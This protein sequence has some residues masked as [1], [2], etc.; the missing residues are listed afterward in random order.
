MK[1]LSYLTAFYFIVFGLTQASAACPNLTLSYTHP[2]QNGCGVPQNIVFNNTSTGTAANNNTWYYWRVNGV[3]VDSSINTIP[4]FTYSFGAPGNYTVRMI[5]RTAGNCRDSI[6]QNIVI[7]SNTP[8]VYNGAALLSYQPI[9]NNCILNP[10]QN[11]N[12][13]IN[14]AS[15]VLLNNYTIIWGD[16]SPNASGVSLAIG[17]AVTHTYTALGLY[18]VRIVT[19]NGTCTDTISGTVF[20]LRPVSTSIKPLPSGQLAGCAPHA[21]TF[22]D[23][24]QNALPGT[25]LTWNF[26]DGNI[27]IR[28]WTQANQPI[29]HTYMPTGVGNCVYTVSLRAFNPNCNTG[30][31]NVSTYTISPVLIFDKDD[32]RI[33]PPTN[34]CLPS[35][36]YTFGNSSVDNCITGQRYYYWDFGD[37]NNSGWITSKGPQTHTFPSYG[38]YT[39][40]LID[41]NGCGS[42]TTYSTVVL[43]TPPQ[44]G[45]TLTP[46]FGCA[47]LTVAVT[48][49]SIGIGNT[50]TWTFT[51]GTPA[52]STLVGRNVTYNN[53][54]TYIVRLAISN[55]C[56]TN[57]IRRDTVRV[58][59]KPIVQIGNAVSGCAP[60]TI[61]PINNTVNQS[62]TATY[63]WD[64]GNGQTS[65]Q[66]NPGSIT[67]NNG[68]NFNIKLVVKDTCG[69]D[70]QLVS[71]T[72][73]T[74]PIAKFSADT[75]CRNTA[76][77]FTGNSTLS[78]GDV[79]TQHKWYFGN[80][81]SSTSISTNQNYTYPTHGIFTAVLKITTDKSCVDVDTFSV[82][83]KPI[84]FVSFNYLPANICDK[85][86][87]N[88][89]A[90]AT[91]NIIQH[92]WSF[93]T[94]DTAKI[95]DTSYLFQA[96]GNYTIIYTATNNTGCLASTTQNI[97]ILPNP[98]ARLFRGNSCSNQVTEFKDSSKV[99]FGNTITQWAWDFDNNGITDS[100]T[101]HATFRFLNAGA[102][103]TKL[104]VTTNNG[105]SNTD[106]LNT[107][108][109]LS[110]LANFNPV[111]TS[112]CVN[113]TFT[114][115]NNS[116]GSIVY[117]WNFGDNANNVIESTA[118]PMK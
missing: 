106:S 13:S 58:Y 94:I 37:G 20:N 53:P 45:F 63:Y 84:P 40:M 92:R 103:N 6:Q 41:S 11:D 48:D 97:T 83:V 93:G 66:R 62:P 46:R 71:I 16:G 27:I 109:Y 108:V 72:V 2:G 44:V 52:S 25:I 79:I 22:Q 36:T 99:G 118:T 116:F 35:L 61:N 102:F 70:S 38:N 55:I 23:S 60:H 15:N 80:G 114:F 73:S 69:I 57:V 24:T 54:G 29:S 26:G 10:L 104:T 7:T 101:Q 47:P 42:D 74:L 31:N 113:D 32:A 89:N 17:S 98:D 96:P 34:L 86:V 107:D 105:C 90:T 87:V 81:D 49:T 51:G 68:G 67:Y 78:T 82:L 75:V 43:N 77:L 88:F 14:I 59:A 110:P 1:A 117:G 64:F 4:N 85:Q 12:F 30:P 112:T 100:T 91:S 19:V 8:Q 28:N 9:W 50:R 65:T 76:T 95:E 3:L 5:A 111:S 33:T 18:T 115:N 21:I 39:I 56:A